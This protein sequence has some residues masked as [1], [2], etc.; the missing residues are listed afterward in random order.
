M[1][2]WPGNAQHE[3]TNF[4]GLSRGQ[5]MA[6][7]AS[8]GNKTT[9]IR[10]ASLL[11]KAALTGWRRHYRL[12]GRPDFV[13]QA[14]KVA[15][16]VDGCFWHGHNCGKNLEPKTNAS[17]WRNKIRKNRTRDLINNKYLRKKGWTVLR[18]WECKLAN[19]PEV[20]VSIIRK[21]VEA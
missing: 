11:K 15:V 6:R 14:S 19:R 18:I 3:R 13:W 21:A 2:R 10:L 8:R 20:C 4:G 16:F 17:A 1:S 5:L 12:S 9:E 7:I